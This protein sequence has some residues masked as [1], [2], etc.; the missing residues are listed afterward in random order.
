MRRLLEHDV[1]ADLVIVPGT[2]RSS[3]EDITRA[4]DP[5]FATVQAFLAEPRSDAGRR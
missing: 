2:H 4:G 5:V 3:I 1:P